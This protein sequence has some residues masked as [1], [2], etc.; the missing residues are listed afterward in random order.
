MSPRLILTTLLTNAVVDI[1][2]PRK[3]TVDLF[4]QRKVYLNFHKQLNV[5]RFLGRRLV[6]MITCYREKWGT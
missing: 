1:Y 3:T 6:F 2:R 4:N 5:A